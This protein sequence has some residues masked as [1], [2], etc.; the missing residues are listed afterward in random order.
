MAVI[1]GTQ[2]NCGVVQQ[3]KVMIV[4]KQ[5]DLVVEKTI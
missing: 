2:M 5:L 3:R 4:K 1:N